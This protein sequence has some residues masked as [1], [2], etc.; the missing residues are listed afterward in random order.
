[1]RRWLPILFLLIA[2]VADA[3]DVLW[4]REAAAN[5]NEALPLGNGRLGAMVFGGPRRERIQLNESS[6]WAGE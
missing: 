3:A 2:G 6:V 5:W 4:Y 1:M